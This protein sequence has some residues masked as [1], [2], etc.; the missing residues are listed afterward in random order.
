[1]GVRVTLHLYAVSVLKI[2]HSALPRVLF[3]NYYMLVVVQYSLIVSFT[4]TD[5]M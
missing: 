3:F 2:E 4:F 1:M 5:Y